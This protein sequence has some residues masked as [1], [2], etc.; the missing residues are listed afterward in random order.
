MHMLIIFG[1]KIVKAFSTL[2]HLLSMTIMFLNHLSHS[3]GHPYHTGDLLQ[4]VFARR[5]ALFFNN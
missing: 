4:L 5:P 3:G 1:K 2:K